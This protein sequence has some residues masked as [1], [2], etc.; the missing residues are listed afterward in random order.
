MTTSTGLR[1]PFVALTALDRAPQGARRGALSLA[2]IVA[3]AFVGARLAPQLLTADRTRRTRRSLALAGAVVSARSVE[4]VGAFAGRRDPRR[5]CRAAAAARARL[6]R[7]RS[8]SAPRP[9]SRS[10]GSRAPSRC[11]CPGQSDLRARG[12]AVAR[13]CSE[14]NERRAAAR[15]LDALARVD[16]FPR[17]RGPLAPVAPPD[18]ALLRQPGV[19]ARRAERRARARHGLRARHRGQRLG[20]R[21]AARRHRRA[22]RRRLQDARSS[23]AAT[24]TVRDASSSRST[25]ANDVAVL[26]SPGSALRPL[27]LVDAA[28]GQA[29]AILGYPENGP[30]TAMPGRIGA[31]D[32]RAHRRRLRPRPGRRARSRRSRGDVR[33]GNSGGPAV[34]AHGAVA[35]DGLRR[36]RRLGR[37]LRRPDATSSRDARRDARARPVSTGACVALGERASSDRRA[38]A[39]TAPRRRRP[40]PSRATPSISSRASSR[41]TVGRVGAGIA[42]RA[43]AP[44]SGTTIPGTSLW[45]R[46][47]ELVARQRPD[48]D[49]QRDRRARRRAARG[50]RRGTR[51][52]T[53]PAS[54]RTARPASSLRSKRSSSTSRSSADGL[55]ATPRKN[56]V[57]ASIAAA[58]Q[59]LAAV[60]LRETSAVRPIASTS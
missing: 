46:T 15:L 49:E 40:P 7:R 58:V 35:D 42:Q 45:M 30:F 13:S 8:C 59:V 50:T 39:G 5:R 21:A 31:D 2:G 52:R 26:R 19:R 29:V 56:D 57:G 24:A 60:Q 36:A 54:S 47:R 34:D 33:H 22:R 14:L 20:R 28:T 53:A 48:A 44:C 32:G 18:P 41:P 55:T 17:S 23:T 1:S 37:R 38:A 10:S 6:D 25:R 4:T 11:T 51:G 3:G 9:G 16:P 12:A 43:P 27:R